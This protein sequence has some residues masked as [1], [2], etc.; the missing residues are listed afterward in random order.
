MRSR[1]LA[2]AGI[3]VAALGAATTLAGTASAHSNIGTLATQHAVSS[4]SVAP[5]KKGKACYTNNDPSG[6]TGIAVTSANY[7]DDAADDTAGA[8]D[9]SVKKSCSIG[10]VQTTGL[11]Y[12][13]TGPA[14]SV[15][16]LFY[17]NKKGE[18][19]K[20]VKEQDNLSY[21]DSTGTGAL[22]VKLKKAVSLKKGNY[23]VSV[24]A[25][26]TLSAGGQWG[27]E[28]TSN[29]IGN[30]D[31]WENQGGGF[32]VCPTW[33]DVLTCVGYGNDFMVTLSK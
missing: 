5:A 19:G 21:T 9:F 15:N 17:K 20:I 7:S 6:D 23:F 12:N 33:G 14:S 13:G 2:V 1:T 30:I 28:L 3:T 16:V 10:T 31:Q 24:V 26:M 22:G 11:Y 4:H 8:V 32:G 25:N 18:P 29:Q 27:W